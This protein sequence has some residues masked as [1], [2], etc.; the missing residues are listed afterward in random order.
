MFLTGLLSPKNKEYSKIILFCRGTFP[1]A[2][3]LTNDDTIDIVF[4]S[5][6]IHSIT[7]LL[8]LLVSTDVI[9]TMTKATWG[10]KGYFTFMIIAHH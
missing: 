5:Q 1:W 8:Y 4:K 3:K 6:K 2:T 10:G 7:S 9:N